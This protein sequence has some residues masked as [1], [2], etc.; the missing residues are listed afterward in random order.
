MSHSIIKE[1]ARIE[2]GKASYSTGVPQLH[3]L[4]FKLFLSER[5]DRSIVLLYESI[6]EVLSVFADTL[7]IK[8]TSK[9]R[10][11]LRA[12]HYTEHTIGWGKSSPCL[13]WDRDLKIKTGCVLLSRG[14]PPSTIAAETLHFCVRYGN[15]CFLLAITT[16]KIHKINQSHTIGITAASIRFI[17]VN[18]QASRLISTG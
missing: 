11:N 3:N 9:N 18:D 6:N 12:Q 8:K 15:R 16:G 14:Q 4:L 1:Q 10:S 2:S 17:K 5:L 7:S 13:D